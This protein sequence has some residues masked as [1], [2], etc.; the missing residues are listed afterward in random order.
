MM[1]S[2]YLSVVSHR[3]EEMIVNNFQGLPAQ[4]GDFAVR[5]C[6][7]DN[8]GSPLLEQFARA[9]R[10]LYYHDGIRRGFG[11]NHNK[12]FAVCAPADD[13]LFIVCNPDVTIEP[14]Q[15]AGMA[16]RFTDS[17][18]DMG[19]VRCYYDKA[20]TR[21]SNPDRR[22]P[23]L[24]DYVASALLRRRLYY[25]TN[26]YV[27]SPEWMSGEFMMFRPAAYR[28]IGGFDE[29]YF[30]YMEDV[31]LCYRAR[32]AGLSIRHDPAHFVVHET[33]AAS[34]NIASASFLMHLA[35]LL[36]YLRKHRNVF[37]RKTAL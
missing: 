23:S 10:H 1:K 3:Q 2:L 35:S 31:D 20:R 13:D 32:K 36:K 33:Q 18:A 14:E 29:E 16:E 6:L 34:R 37:F 15:L 21:F 28:A 12:A 17:R 22:F 24:L 5:L 26:E 8:S 27:V 4:A 11:A 30:M 19:N 9:S 25:G 7:I